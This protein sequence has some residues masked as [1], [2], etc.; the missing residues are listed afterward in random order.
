MGSRHLS[1]AEKVALGIAIPTGLYAVILGLLLTP[2]FQRLYAIYP[3][4]TKLS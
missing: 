4:Y 3:K 1:L 2:Y